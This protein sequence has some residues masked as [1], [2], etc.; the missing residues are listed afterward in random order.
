MAKKNRIYDNVR[1]L[2]EVPLKRRIKVE[3]SRGNKIIPRKYHNTKKTEERARGLFLEMKK[4]VLNK[5]A[6]KSVEAG[7][8]VPFRPTGPYCGA[9]I[10]LYL[11]GV[12]KFH[13]LFA[14]KN[15]MQEYMSKVGV[16]KEGLS[17]WQRFDSKLPR[18]NATKAQDTK[19]RIIDNMNV[20]QRL[21]GYNPCGN[22]LAEIG[23]CIDIKKDKD[24]NFSYCL[25]THFDIK[26]MMPGRDNSEYDKNKSERKE[27]SQQIEKAKKR[28]MKENKELIDN[29]LIKKAIKEE[30]TSSEEVI[31]DA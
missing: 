10:A 4:V 1:N 11:L 24:G 23:C 9:V 22:K 13:E 2:T 20:L 27:F 26:T 21:G 29:L 30:T 8:Y 12:N 28:K 15:K 16:D 17:A 3:N 18:E 25:N 6:E 31:L 5:E 14:V 19:G 7:F